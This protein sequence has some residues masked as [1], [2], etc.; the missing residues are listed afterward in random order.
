VAD[1]G[2][3]METGEIVMADTCE[4]L[5]CDEKLCD[6]YLGGKVDPATF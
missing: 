1:R 2:Y 6:A 3:V 4:G 5:L